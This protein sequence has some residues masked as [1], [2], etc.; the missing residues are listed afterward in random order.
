MGILVITQYPVRHIDSL[1]NLRFRGTRLIEGTHP[2]YGIVTFLTNPDPNQM[3]GYRPDY[4]IV[5][6]P[7]DRNEEVMRE[8]AICMVARNRKPIVA[9]SIAGI[10]DEVGE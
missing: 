2:T 8:A 10:F 7:M 9:L 5:V 4:L 1:T 6:N 3:R